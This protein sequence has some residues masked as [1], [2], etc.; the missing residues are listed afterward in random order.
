MRKRKKHKWKYQVNVR[1]KILVLLILGVFLF[2]G[3]GYAILEADLGISG[4]LDVSKYDR[5]L[6][7]ALKREVSRGYA[8]KY[9]G[10]HQD[11]M[12]P[13]KSTEDIYHFYA[14]TDQKGT[15]IL[16]KNNVVFAEKCWQMIRTTDTGGVKL[17]YNGDPEIT[18]VNNETQYNCG[19]TKTYKLGEILTSVSLR[20]I[21]MYAKNYTVGT[22]DNT[23]TFTL[24]DDPNDPDDT[25]TVEVS[26]YAAA[27]QI[28]YIAENYPYVCSNGTNSCTNANF[29]KVISHNGGVNANAYRSTQGDNIGISAYNT[30]YNS[31][32]FVGYMYGDVYP[33]KND[34]LGMTTNEF[35]TAEVISNNIMVGTDLEDNGDST[36]TIKNGINQAE[37]VDVD[38]WSS[39]Y[40]NYV[41]KY[42]CGTVSDTCQT[43]RFITSTT[44][45]GYSYITDF[46]SQ[47]T[48]AKT[49]NNLELTDYIT[50][51][52]LAW[53]SNYNTYSEYKYTC[54]DT[55]TTCT[56]ANLQYISGYTSSG[57]TYSPNHYFGR[58]VVYDETDQMYKLQNYEGLETINDL[59]T[60][61]T[62]HYVCK[63]L[64]TKECA[65]VAY[66]YYYNGSEKM[67]YITLNDPNVESVQDAL[68]EMLKKNTTSSTIKRNI[69]KWYET[70]LLNTV[71]ETKLDD[72]IYCNDR[73]FATTP[74]RTFA[75]SGWNDNGGRTNRYLYFKESD[76]DKD[77]D[78][79][80]VEDKFSVSN[81][82]A[83]LTYKI[84]LIRKN[85]MMLLNK[86]SA[87]IN[88]N[89]YYTI[90]PSPFIT[91]TGDYWINNDGSAGSG[92]LGTAR[93]VRPSISLIAGTR[94]SR[95]N[96]SKNNP[97][98]VDMS[99]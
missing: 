90:S 15:E 96:G 98:V 47:I 85:E 23:T 79:T 81:N 9:T 43:P 20:G 71:Y 29:Y 55:S 73:R 97:Y 19:D 66:V 16:N 91:S 78:C 40:E 86:N 31:P 92:N 45:T 3:V 28:A 76:T 25:Y 34:L 7:S 42:T 11:S 84:G 1:K 64:G 6:Y 5:T 70:N 18:V 88:E 17:L 75:D 8:T 62:H 38:N 58:S 80:N 12:N 44:E 95:G 53:Y 54:G 83:K 39:D 4:S 14:T 48:I 56:E 82:A 24:V 10:N 61:S 13:A 32:A 37:E 60:L 36:F 50:V 77:L 94:Y 49:R 72:T 93:G 69:D 59:T 74:G 57:Y 33:S 41:G 63:D 87:R 30:G 65:E 27:S 99:E 21:K 67:Y 26:Y 68:D 46:N 89:H 52:K 35:S 51:S 22:S 2:V